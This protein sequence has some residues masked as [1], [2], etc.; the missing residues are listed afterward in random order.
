MSSRARVVCACIAAAAV[1]AC[2]GQPA[3]E[4]PLPTAPPLPTPT[5]APTPVDPLVVLA[6][7]GRV[8]EALE[9]FHF[10]LDHSEGFTALMPNLSLVQAEGDVVKPDGMSVDLSGGAGGFA[11]KSGF[12]TSGDDSFMLNPL[13]GRWD[14]SPRE[15]SPLDFFDPQRGISSMMTDVESPVLTVEGRVY[16]IEGHLP[17]EALSP[18]IGPTLDGARVSVELTIAV[19]SHHLERAVFVGAVK[20]GEIEGTVRTITLSGFDD[21]VVIEAPR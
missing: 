4:A 14:P 19:G 15:A 7:S 2:G 1:I 8:M 21:P 17:A 13:T 12:I 10:R 9:S 5:P 6:E 3:G 18:L 16:S 11:I 20:A